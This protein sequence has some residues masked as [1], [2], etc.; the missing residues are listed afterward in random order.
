MSNAK[1]WALLCQQQADLIDSLT[2]LLPER[3]DEHT[4]LSEHW[5][6]MSVRIACGDVILM[7]KLKSD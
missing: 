3:D 2:Q 1:K 6:Q 7:P 5:R 4:H